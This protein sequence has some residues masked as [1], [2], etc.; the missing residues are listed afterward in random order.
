MRSTGVLLFTNTPNK[1]LGL[2]ASKKKV[3][4]L[5]K[6]ATRDALIPIMCLVGA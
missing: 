3:L 1:V 6:G 4:G 2:L 5:R